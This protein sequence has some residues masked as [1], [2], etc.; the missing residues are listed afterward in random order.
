MNQEYPTFQELLAARMR[1]K[2]VTLKRLAEATG[3]APAHLE[4][5]LHGNFEDM[6][7]Q[8][9]FHGY[10]LRVAKV[11]DFDGEE[12]WGKLKREGAVKNSGPSDALPKN[13]FVKKS[14]PKKLWIAIAVAI[15]V[16]VYLA[17]AFPRI[18]G[19]PVLTITS[20]IGNPYTSTS[21][22]ITIQGTVDNA[23]SLSLNGDVVTI[24]PDGTWQKGV[25]LQNGLNT[26]AITAKKFLGQE[27]DVT[28]DIL[29][30]SAT[31]TSTATTTQI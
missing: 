5:M 30:E 22:T 25:L 20:P 17:I 29:Y 1:D 13:R 7:S 11:L 27:T 2:G 24:A 6:P 3:I 10:V 18:V 28:E 21:T 19:K 26:F 14:P 8:P 16:I 15:V 9:Y 31:S 12:W 23:D 4:N